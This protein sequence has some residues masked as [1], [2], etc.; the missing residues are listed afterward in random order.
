MPRDAKKCYFYPLQWGEDTPSENSE[1]LHFL[2]RTCLAISF[3]AE[4][5]LRGEV[6][7]FLQTTGMSFVFAKVL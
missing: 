3:S 4:K 6:K 5:I 2:L 1:E 7:A